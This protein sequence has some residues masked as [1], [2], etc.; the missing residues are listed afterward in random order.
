M[1]ASRTRRS[2]CSP[3]RRSSPAAAHRLRHADHRSPRDEPRRRPVPDRSIHGGGRRRPAR[4]AAEPVAGRG[5]REPGDGA[6]LPRP[7]DRGG[8]RVPGGRQAPAGEGRGAA[9]LRRHARD[10]PSDFAETPAAPGVYPPIGYPA[11]AEKADGYVDYYNRLDIEANARF[12]KAN[13]EYNRLTLKTPAAEAPSAGHLAEPRL[14]PVPR[15]AEGAAKARYTTAVAQGHA[16]GSS[17]HLAGG[18]GGTTRS[19]TTSTSARV[20]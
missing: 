1:P 12:S 10:R 2:R 14:G 9:H 5:S 18:R 16:I 13:D 15:D 7:G 17:H 20:R 3:R 8:V 11:L 19:S 4:P 6:A